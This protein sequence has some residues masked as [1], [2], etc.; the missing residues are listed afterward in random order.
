MVDPS[1]GPSVQ[2]RDD[3]S[4]EDVERA[5]KEVLADC[6]KRK[7]QAGRRPVGKKGIY[8]T[9]GRLGKGEKI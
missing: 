2:I 3:F 8:V 5:A 4:K 7:S 9:V 1:L 6:V